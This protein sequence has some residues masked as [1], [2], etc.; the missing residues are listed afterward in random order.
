MQARSIRRLLH[1]SHRI[2]LEELVLAVDA[3]VL[4]GCPNSD[5]VDAG[6]QSSGQ[7]R[8]PD[9]GSLHWLDPGLHGIGLTLEQLFEEWIGSNNSVHLRRRGIA[10]LELDR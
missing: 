1:R 6:L 7:G 4:I 3:A 8:F 9:V 5:G 2:D 10:N